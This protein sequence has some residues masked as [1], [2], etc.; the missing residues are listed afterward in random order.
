MCLVDSSMMEEIT[1]LRKNNMDK[2]DKT[3]VNI[4]THLSNLPIPDQNNLFKYNV[5]QKRIF[6]LQKFLAGLLGNHSRTRN[7][8]YSKLRK[9]NDALTSLMRINNFEYDMTLNEG[10]E[11][12]TVT[13]SS[14]VSY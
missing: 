8:G 7:I 12:G 10:Q 1:N 4:N 13:L 9:Y 11:G 6:G 3:P 5:L 2:G 14:K